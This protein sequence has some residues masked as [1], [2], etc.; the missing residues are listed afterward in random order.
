MLGK[1]IPK[2][3]R[4]TIGQ[5]PYYFTCAR[6]DA[7]HDHVCEAD[8][9][10]GK[11]IDWEHALYFKGSK[12]QKIFAII[13]SCWW[14]HR[15]PGLNKEINVWIALNRASDAELEAY[16]KAEDL[17]VKR[18]RLNIKYGVY[19]APQSLEPVLHP[20]MIGTAYSRYAAKSLLN[21]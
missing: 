6:N 19:I 21:Y 20:E 9:L 12:L 11:L 4:I 18:D 3:M 7:L 17:K 14:A 8:P 10:N 16:S 5:D 2:K 13:P 1:P 15:G